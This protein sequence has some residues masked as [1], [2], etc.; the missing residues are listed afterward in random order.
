MKTTLEKVFSWFFAFMK[1][2]QKPLEGTPDAG[3]GET[4]EKQQNNVKCAQ[5]KT[6]IMDEHMEKV[7]GTS[8][9]TPFCILVVFFQY[10]E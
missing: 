2:E 9:N 4:L 3:S 5:K 1:M 10:I 6:Q 8:Q 7:C